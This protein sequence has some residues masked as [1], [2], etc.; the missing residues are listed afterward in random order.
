M[1]NHHDK[2]NNMAC[3]ASKD[4]DSES[5][6]CA[7]AQT[8]QSLCCLHEEGL[9]GFRTHMLF[10]LFCHVMAKINFTEFFSQCHL[11]MSLPSQ[12]PK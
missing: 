4:P 6:G 10:C 11:K 2:T 7:S 12:L 5:E 1:V 3:A 9:D 8:D